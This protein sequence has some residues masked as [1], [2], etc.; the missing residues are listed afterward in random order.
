[1]KKFINKSMLDTQNMPIMSDFRELVEALR[2]SEKLVYWA[3]NDKSHG[4]YK[5]FSI[6]KKD[7]TYRKLNVPATSIKV[8]QRWILENILY[9]TS[10]SQYSYG[11]KKDVNGSPLVS[12]VEKHKDNMY[13]LKMDLKN[14]YPSIKKE[15]IFYQFINW[16][17]N[18]EIS[19]LLTNICTCEDELPQGAVTSACLANIVCKHMDIRIAGYCNKREITYTRYADDMMFSCNNR[20]TL[21]NIYGMIGKIV[22]SEGFTLNE[23]KTI[24]MT[25]KGHKK[26]L[27]LTVNDGL[28]KVSKQLKNEIR[29]I[30][31]YHIATGDYRDIEKTKGYISFIASIEK[32]Y[33][34]KITKYISRL[35]M[36]SLSMF[37]EIVAAYNLNKFFAELPDMELRKAEDFVKFNDINV[38]ED[39]VYCEH[40]NYLSKHGLIEVDYD[41]K[42]DYDDIW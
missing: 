8:I 39:F 34:N 7:G 36:S 26:L 11:F 31:H 12:C 27:G 19:N 21:R 23:K 41:D 16:G 1:M 5:T 32:D 20:L 10:T 28:V 2:L 4:R 14:F 38:F 42:A 29:A 33:K 40:Q 3:S 25:P 22:N 15:R 9:K 18:D 13:V 24:F 30:I 37:P 17:Y 35:S 6:P